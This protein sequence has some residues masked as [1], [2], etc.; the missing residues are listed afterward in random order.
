MPN[1]SRRGAN[2]PAVIS[3]KCLY[4]SDEAKSRMGWKDPAW[5]IAVSKGLVIT[6]NGRW[7]Y[8]RGSDLIEYLYRDQD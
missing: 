1:I 7:Q 5:R 3:P 8:V 4:R 6:K 2:A